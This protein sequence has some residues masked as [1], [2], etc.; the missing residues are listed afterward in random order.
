MQAVDN[1]LVED[2]N[3]L[4]TENTDLVKDANELQTNDGDDVLATG[5]IDPEINVTANN[6]TYDGDAT[7]DVSVVDKNDSTTS[8]TTA[9]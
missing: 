5:E 9:L 7:I 3:N 8:L 6:V 2:V 4:Q 1:D